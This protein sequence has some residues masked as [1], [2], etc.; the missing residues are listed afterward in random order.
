MLIGSTIGKLAATRGGGCGQLV[1][2]DDYSM[3]AELII[4]PSQF[5]ILSSSS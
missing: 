3:T 5:F 2:A 1:L 4:F